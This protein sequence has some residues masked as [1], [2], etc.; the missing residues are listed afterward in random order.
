M[1]QGQKTI[2]IDIV[3]CC[4]VCQAALKARVEITQMHG[5]TDLEDFLCMIVDPCETC[6]GRS[7]FRGQ[8]DEIKD[9]FARAGTENSDEEVL[10]AVLRM[11]KERGL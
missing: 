8:N 11:R 5:Y 3:V 1:N 10:G 7:Y 9:S 2:G 4:S 6:T